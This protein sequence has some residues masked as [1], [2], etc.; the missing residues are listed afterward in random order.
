MK[1]QIDVGV[2]ILET[3]ETSDGPTYMS[4]WS[5]IT[6][7]LCQW[8]DELGIKQISGG[9]GLGYR[10]QQFQADGTQEGAVDEFE[11]RFN[12]KYVTGLTYPDERKPYFGIGTACDPDW[13]CEC[14]SLCGCYCVCINPETNTTYLSELYPTDTPFVPTHPDER[15]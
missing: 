12:L 7:T 1:Y 8:A 14:E 2:P 9:T 3:P 4:Q 11:R 5:D 10:D 13:E 15:L 6:D